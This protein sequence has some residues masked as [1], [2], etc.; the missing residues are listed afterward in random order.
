[1][2]NL[3]W[4]QPGSGQHK[5]FPAAS[6]LLDSAGNILV[7]AYPVLRPDGQWSLLLVNRDQENSH[8]VRI[9]FHDA[10]ADTDRSFSG[11]LNVITFGSEQYRWR[12]DIGKGTAVPDGPAKRSTLAADANTTYDLPKASLTVIRGK[13]GA[14]SSLSDKKQRVETK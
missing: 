1:L 10:K 7:T 13:T 9:V 14:V 5:I 4:V 6:D 11:T 3:E 8:S 2:I 12:P